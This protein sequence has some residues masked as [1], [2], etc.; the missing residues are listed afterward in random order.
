MRESRKMVKKGPAAAGADLTRSWYKNLPRSHLPCKDF[1]TWRTWSYQDLC[2]IFCSGAVQYR[3]MQGP[4]REEFTRISTRARSRENL[5]WTCR[6]PRAWEPGGA[7]FVRACAVEMHMDTSEDT[8]YAFSAGL[9]RKQAAPQVRDQHFE[10]ACAVEM[11]MDIWQE[12]WI[13]R[14]KTGDQMK[15]PDLTPALTPTVRNPQCGHTVWGKHPGARYHRPCQ[16]HFWM[17]PR[18]K[19]CQFRWSSVYSVQNWDTRAHVYYN[20]HTISYHIISYHI[21]SYHIII[22]HH[23]ISYH[24]TSYHIM[25]CHI[26]S[27]HIMSRHIISYHIISSYHHIIISSYHTISSYH[28]TSYH[29]MSYYDIFC[30]SWYGVIK[31]VLE[32]TVCTAWPGRNIAQHFK[33]RPQYFR[34]YFGQF[35]GLQPMLNLHT[36]KIRNCCNWKTRRMSIFFLRTEQLVGFHRVVTRAGHVVC[37]MLTTQGAAKTAGSLFGLSGHMS[38]KPLETH[39]CRWLVFVCILQSFSGTFAKCCKLIFWSI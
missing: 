1:K 33:S 34:L 39:R 20:I 5:Q 9:C 30:I 28:I 17:T 24:V 29:I 6:R 2:K 26:K 32:C 27:Y 14:K 16:T 38:Q 4:L 37:S 22:S 35:P 25:S 19:R 13:Y 10:Q 15:H 11:H 3:I 12:P 18:L 8:F 23:I 36:T 21:I 31:N 7:D